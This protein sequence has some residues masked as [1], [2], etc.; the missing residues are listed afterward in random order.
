MPKLSRG[1]AYLDLES[2]FAVH[3]C[4]LHR[5][6]KWWKTIEQRKAG[7]RIA[8]ALTY[9]FAV[10][11]SFLPTTTQCWESVYQPQGQHAGVL[12]LN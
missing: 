3:N 8:G 4:Q 11:A 7:E 1:S 12:D 9:A 2:I 10:Y 6:S 5:T